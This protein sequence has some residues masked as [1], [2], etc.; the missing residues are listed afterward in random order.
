MSKYTFGSQ[1]VEYLGHIISKEWIKLDPKKIS[2]MLEWFLPKSP[3]TLR[4]FLGLTEYRKYVKVYRGISTPL[5]VLLKKN[6]FYWIEDATSVFNVLKTTM[7]KSPIL[8]FSKI[9]VIECD[10]FGEGLGVVLM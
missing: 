6:V 7:V 5:T 10:T 3:K 2:A 8:D 9:F 1:E 4:G